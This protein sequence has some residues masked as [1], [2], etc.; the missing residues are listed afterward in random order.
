MRLS[1][2][3][4]ILPSSLT[5]VSVSSYW[6]TGNLSRLEACSNTSLVG[7]IIMVVFS[8]RVGHEKWQL[9]GFMIIQTALIASMASVGINDKAQA[10]A[11]V[12]I[13]GA[14]VTT[15]Q[16]ISFAMLS[17]GLEDQTDM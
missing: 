1:Y 12:L 11:V 15:P 6:Q 13:T 9:T 7:A 3:E 8:S 16:L 10:I 5:V 2:V 17:L 14:A 4:F